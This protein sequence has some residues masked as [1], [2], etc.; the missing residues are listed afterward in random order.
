M[1]RILILVI[2]LQL[3]GMTHPALALR[4]DANTADQTAIGQAPARGGTRL[5]REQVDLIK[6]A[7][8]NGID[9]RLRPGRAH[10]FSIRGRQLGARRSFSG[11]IGLVAQ[12]KGAHEQDAI[13]VLDNLSRMLGIRNAQREF[14]ARKVTADHLGYHHVR[15]RQEHAGLRVVGADLTVHFDNANDPYQV[16]G[17]YVPDLDIDPVAQ[18]DAV[19]AVQIARRDL[20]FLKHASANIVDG[21]ELVVFARNTKPVLA[22]ELTFSTAGVST[23]VPG[24]WRFWID[25]DSGKIVSRYNDIK[26]IAAPTSNGYHTTITGSVL[27][28]E[29]GIVKSVTGWYENTGFY[30]LY[31]KD[32]HWYLYN[33]ATNGF[34]DNNTYAYRSTATWGTGDRAEMSGA[35]A[36][37]AAQDYYSTIHGLNSYDGADAYARAN[38]HDGNYANAYWSPYEQQF[39]FG[40][41][42]GVTANALTVM[43]V[44]AHEFTH[45]VTEHSANLVY[46]YES[47]ALNESFSDIFGACVEFH[48]QSDGSASY[49]YAPPGYADWLMGED[50]WLETTALR[51]MRDPGNS[52]TVGSDGVQ[53]TVYFG[54]NWHTEAWDNGGVHINS[55]I[56]NH[57]FYLLCEGGSGSNDGI[58]YNL[59]GIGISN[60]EQIA[61]RALTVYCTSE[62]D[63]RDCRLAWIA[64][65]QDLN[66][67][68][69]AN[70]EAA[71]S[72]VG[73]GP[74]A[75][76]P[77][78]PAGFDGDY[79]GPFSPS[80][81]VP[82]LENYGGQPVTWQIIDCPS[83][84]TASPSSG[85]LAP[86][87]SVWPSLEL[88]PSAYSLPD[89]TYIGQMKL[90]NAAGTIMVS[91]TVSLRIGQ[92]HF[93]TELFD[94]A[95]FD[96]DGLSMTFTPDGSQH[97]YSVQVTPI[98]TLPVSS[99]GHAVI[100]LS[101]DNYASRSLTGTSTIKLYGSAYATLYIGSNGYITFGTGDWIFSSSL[102]NHFSLPRISAFYTDLDPSAGGSV[103]WAQLEDRVV[104][105]YTAVPS[106]VT[107]E[108]NTFQ[109]EMYFDGRITLSW[110]GIDHLY[111]L[112][113]LSKPSYGGLPPDYVETDLSR[114]GSDF[115]CDGIPNDWELQHFGGPTNCIAWLDSDGDGFCN[116]EEY[117]AGT[118]PLDALSHF[119][120]TA[121]P[122]PGDAVVLEWY[123]VEGRDYTIYSRDNLVSGP[124]T[125]LG[126]SWYPYNTYTAAVSE[127]K[128]QEFYDIRVQLQ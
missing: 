89:G 40:D 94:A 98:S 123:A 124:S 7:S 95:D 74:L 12:G 61:F 33:V 65:A 125:E 57:F 10:R 118:L 66:P 119:H 116:I 59:T 91:K 105:T 34:P 26:D 69:V 90:G 72:A 32:N 36:L 99:A 115:D 108:L 81:H 47:G 87:Q 75:I 88:T 85:T 4:P 122:M 117:I 78:S 92:P 23:G 13:A 62:T 37:D 3:G 19:S 126:E 8:S 56:Q 83:W 11:G 120:A 106:W 79:G 18:L 96:L 110:L 1:K 113:G 71:W 114:F 112:V 21:P 111:G 25:A 107:G 53:P 104:V 55:S 121:T 30:Y 54:T 17:T 20:A 93:Y 63:Y 97:F 27:A 48:A 77:L 29:G 102:E 15:M 84:C 41:G 45:A 49:P 73:V 9:V 76:D 43:D 24:F 51:D 28:G 42:D 38:I 80:R 2:G 103:R 82:E 128:S 86:G 22:Y 127:V 31:N 68:W 14:T 39:Y 52:G 109:C 58:T 67:G 46:S 6:E 16:N 60:A 5:S 50:C 101:D 70:V 100:T 44:V 35:V 64:A